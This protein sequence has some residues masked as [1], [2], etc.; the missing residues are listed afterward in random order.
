MLTIDKILKIQLS[1]VFPVN[2][3][4]QFIC[5]NK[6]IKVVETHNIIG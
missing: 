1:Y 3:H 6:I 5:I 4:N 2:F